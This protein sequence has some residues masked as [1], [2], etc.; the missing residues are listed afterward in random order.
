MWRR[1]VYFPFLAFVWEVHSFFSQTIFSTASEKLKEFKHVNKTYIHVIVY[2]STL[3]LQ[4][5]K[6]FWAYGRTLQQ[7]AR[8]NPPLESGGVLSVTTVPSGPS[9]AASGADRLKSDHTAVHCFLTIGCGEKRCQ[10]LHFKSDYLLNYWTDFAEICFI[11][12]LNDC[13]I[14][15]WSFFVFFTNFNFFQTCL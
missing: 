13:S 3:F 11:L 5:F 10:F 1:H 15:L 6:A 7:P 12:F 9:R 2:I 8:P 14:W 4:I